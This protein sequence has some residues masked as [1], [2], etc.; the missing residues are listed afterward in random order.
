MKKTL[1]FVILIIT[2]VSVNAQKLQG[3][4][5][6]LGGF[7][8]E[9]IAG[10]G[11]TNLMSE[12]FDEAKFTYNLGVTARKEFSS[13]KDGK[14]GLYGIT[15]LIFTSRAGKYDNTIET[16]VDDDKNARV[17]G[18]AVPIHIGGEYKFSKVSLFCDLGPNVFFKTGCSD[19]DNF[20]ASA[21]TFGAGIEF[22]VRFTRFA[23]SFGYDQDIT[24]IAKFTPDSNQ[25]DEF[26]LDKESY[27][28]KSGEL[29]LRLRWTLGKK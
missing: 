2:S 21:V 16:L 9:I 20:D 25:K 29:H 24:N 1:L 5:N 15:G 6:F 13:F 23:I 19:I 27:S 8:Y 11:T 18:V 17:N 12:P 22:G 7:K 26:E 10:Y 3:V 14:I 4:K 28:F